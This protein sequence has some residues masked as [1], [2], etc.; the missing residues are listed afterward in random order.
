MVVFDTSEFL[1]NKD[2]ILFFVLSEGLRTDLKLLLFSFCVER[3][4]CLI[5][6]LFLQIIGLYRQRD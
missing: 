3:S 4:L 2:E 6:Q 5:S 1:V